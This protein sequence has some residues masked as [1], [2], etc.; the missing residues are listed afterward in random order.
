MHKLITF[1]GS[2]VIIAHAG[3]GQALFYNNGAQVTLTGGI[4]VMIEGSVE[5]TGG[6]VY[7]TNHSNDIIHVLGDWTNNNAGDQATGPGKILFEG[8]V[9][10]TM[11]NHSGGNDYPNVELNNANDLTVTGG[12]AT[13]SG[14]LILTDGKVIIGN[15]DVEAQDVTGYDEAAGDWVVTNGTGR[16]IMPLGTTDNVYPIGNSTSQY[17]PVVLSASTAPASTVMVGARTFNEVYDN[18][19]SGSAYAT[20]VGGITWPLT[21]ISGP[22]TGYTITEKVHWR[23]A[24]E[25]PSFDRTNS[26]IGVHTGSPNTWDKVPCDA[27]VASTGVNGSTLDWQQDRSINPSLITSERATAVGNCGHPVPVEW[28]TF[29]A[30]RVDADNVLLTWSTA[31]EKDN[32]GFEVQRRLEHEDE[33][34]VVGFIPGQGNS[35]N[36]TRYQFTDPNAYEGLSYYRLK[37]VDFNGTFE[38]SEIRVVSGIR[39]D[40]GLVKNIINMPHRTVITLNNDAGPVQMRLMAVDGR[41]VQEGRYV[42]N[43]E[44]NKEILSKGGYVLHFVSDDGQTWTYR[45]VVE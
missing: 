5:N 2:G 44:I 35:V 45:I 15:N 30:E 38:Y 13:L 37:Q 16:L 19:L 34:A 8:S 32:K 6:A 40:G 1:I 11:T 33:F 22:T 7:T 3:W 14:N 36:I 4:D 42:G 24:E 31:S 18:G 20:E 41:V 26:A 9:A 39:K 10:Q 28:L 29:E 12:K 25:K 17:N 23:T 43:V 21:I 27:A